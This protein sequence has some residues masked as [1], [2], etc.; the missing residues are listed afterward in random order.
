[1]LAILANTM[2]EEFM[3]GKSILLDIASAA[4]ISTHCPV[5]CF[6]FQ[7]STNLKHASLS[8]GIA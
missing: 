2:P 5:S 3:A 8:H 7:R 4:S 6:F 1:L